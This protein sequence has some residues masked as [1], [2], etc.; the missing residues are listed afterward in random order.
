MVMCTRI[1]ASGSGV[2]R[3]YGKPSGWLR[4]KVVG[5]N[6]RGFPSLLGMSGEDFGQSSPEV[7]KTAT[8]VSGSEF[9]RARSCF[10]IVT[11]VI[12]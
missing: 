11:E 12:V 3:H 9:S 6:L 4:A 8:V 10:A 7:E 1:G 2:D 5:Q